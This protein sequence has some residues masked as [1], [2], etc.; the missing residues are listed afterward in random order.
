M[1]RDLQPAVINLNAHKEETINESWLAMFGGAIEML[2]KQMFGGG[3]N[4]FSS[5]Y[6][7]RGTPTQIAAFGDALGKEKKYMESFLKYGLNDPRSFSSKAELS[8][9]VT[10]FERETSI[11]WPFN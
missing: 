9:A 10:N 8:K 6:S 3:G 11:K 7:V 5:S 4:P 1:S 2:L